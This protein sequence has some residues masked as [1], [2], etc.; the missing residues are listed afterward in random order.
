MPEEVKAVLSMDDD[1]VDDTSTLDE[2]A[3]ALA[4]D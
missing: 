3:L 2:V 4:E 1:S